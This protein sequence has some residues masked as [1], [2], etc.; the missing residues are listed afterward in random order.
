MFKKQK[1]QQEEAAKAQKYLRFLFIGSEG[2]GT[3]TSFIEKFTGTK[4]NPVYKEVLVCG[5]SF[6]LELWDSPDES[7]SDADC[8]VI[9]YDITDRDSYN[10]ALYGS[11]RIFKRNSSALKVVIGNKLDLAD[12]RKVSVS[13]GRILADAANASAY[14]EGTKSLRLLFVH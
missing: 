2:S 3:K 5:T 10:N 8:I 1:K 13:E 11:E 7:V 12:D 9:G 14:Y 6:I 4:G